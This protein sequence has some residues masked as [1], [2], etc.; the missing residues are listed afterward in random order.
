MHNG[1][2][3]FAIAQSRLKPQRPV[4]AFC[5]VLDSD[6]IVQGNVIADINFNE[7]LLLPSF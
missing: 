4:K 1:I 6:L 3:F 7:F 2:K 5:N